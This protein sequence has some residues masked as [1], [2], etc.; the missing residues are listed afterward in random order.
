[1][2][3]DPVKFSLFIIFCG[4]GWFADW[5]HLSSHFQRTSCTQNIQCNVKTTIVWGVLSISAAFLPPGVSLLYVCSPPP[6]I[7]WWS[8]ILCLCLGLF[9][10]THLS[11]H[12]D[13]ISFVQHKVY[14]RSLPPCR[15]QCPEELQWE[16]PRQQAVAFDLQI[17]GRGGR[18]RGLTL[19]G[20]FPDWESGV[21]KEHVWFW[22]PL[23][24]RTGSRGEWHGGIICWSSGIMGPKRAPPVAYREP[25]R[26]SFT[27]CENRNIQGLLFCYRGQKTYFQCQFGILGLP[28]TLST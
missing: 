14:R 5:F 2:L 23:C 26:K 10:W 4:A 13:F 6:S 7:S 15:F 28:K 19:R 8:L 25:W 12:Q 27:A 3:C 11:L 18:G 9:Q 17:A 20:P 22:Y 1:M 21:L 16:T 24:C